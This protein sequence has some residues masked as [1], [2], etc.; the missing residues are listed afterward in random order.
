M[1][2][3]SR[4]ALRALAVLVVFGLALFLRL[5]AVDGLPTD[6]DE[7]DY[8][9]AGQLYAQH[10]AAGDIAGVVNERENYEHPPLTKLIYGA[11]LLPRGPAA[12]A[13]PV[14]AQKNDLLPKGP[15]A[16]RVRELA[17]PLRTFSAYVG[18]LSAALLALVSPPAGL[19]LALSSW[20]I[21]YTAQA[22]LEALPCLFATATLLAL[23]RSRRNGDAWF[24]LSAVALGLAAAGTYRY[25]AGGFA[26]LGWVVWRARRAAPAGTRLRPYGLVAGWLALALLVFYIFDPAL[27]PDPLGRLRASILFNANYSAGQSVADAGFPW[28]QPIFWLLSA[29]PWNPGAAPLRLDG[30]F[31]LAALLALP[32]MWR[33]GDRGALAPR[34][35]ALWLLANLGFL[36]LWPTK[37]PQYTLAMLP[38]AALAAARYG[39]DLLAGWRSRRPP[40]PSERRA[41]RMAW[42]WLLPAGLLMLLVAAYPLLLQLGLAV[43]EFTLVNLRNGQ[44]AFWQALGRGFL[45]LPPAEKNPLN[46]VGMGPLA[47]AGFLLPVLRFNILWV[48]AT[49]ALATW[50]GLSLARLLNQPGLRGRRAWR[51]LFILPWAIPE[52]VAALLWQTIFDDNFGALNNLLGTQIKWLS[53]PTPLIDLA[54]AARPLG[55]LLVRLRLAPLGESLIFIAEG[56]SPPKAFW[57]LTLVGAWVCFPFML[58]VGSAALRAVPAEVYDAARIDGADRRT[59]WRRITWPLIAPAVWGGVLLRGALLFN[60]FY[61]PQ[62]LVGLSNV[63]RTGTVTLA[64]I[65]Y[66]TATYS[67]YSSAAFINT[68]VLIAAGL[69]IWLFS[70]QTGALQGAEDL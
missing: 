12:Y 31:G 13:D 64:L 33:D 25:A 45:S 44:L 9:R 8:L 38:A 26:A 14:A 16:P 53:D 66:F 52:F 49:M 48:A 20:H 6:Y 30:L 67:E 28:V 61:L 4:L 34:L 3:L 1:P 11:L 46:Y 27:W 55:A 22:M 10:L 56:L 54:A 70:R 24:W 35:T 32:R 5:R 43:S 19:L 57:A 37:W 68:I 51:T 50:L 63:D 36:L 17:R 69:L 29:L 7:D 39:A 65:G 47:F 15:D 41:L 23:A 60:A 2:R 59:I 21:K 62:L 58:L 40:G 18:A 42:P